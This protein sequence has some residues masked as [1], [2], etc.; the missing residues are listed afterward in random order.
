MTGSDTVYDNSELFSERY[1]ETGITRQSQWDCTDEAETA[2]S[3][4]VDLYDREYA[5][6]TGYTDNE[7]DTLDKW[8]EPVLETLGYEHLGETGFASGSGFVDRVL[9]ESHEDRVA[10]EDPRNDDDYATVYENAAT[11]LEAKPWDADFSTRFSE[12]RNY[13]NAS[14][15]INYYLS[16]LPRGTV[17]WGILTNGR[18]WRLYGT[19]DHQ[20]FIY[21][22]VDLPALIE[23]NETS[24]FKYFYCLF[25]SAAFRRST[26]SGECFLDRV[27]RASESTARQL[28]DDLQDNVFEAL[29]ILGDGFIATNDLEVTDT[30][31]ITPASLRIDGPAA[32]GF[33]LDDL[34]EQALI[35]LYRLMF[36]FYAES[37]DLLQPETTDNLRTY[38]AELSLIELRDEIVGLNDSPE[39]TAAT[40]LRRSTTH[41]QRLDTFFDIIDGGQE[42]IGIQAYDGGLF[43]QDEHEF[44]NQHPVSNHHLA[45]VI[46][47]LS[48][49]KI[50]E[51]YETVDYDDLKTRHLGAVYEGL[52]EHQFRLASTDMVAIH[53]DD[54][55]VWKKATEVKDDTATVDH[56]AAGNLYVATDEL[57]R[58]VSGSY[59][60]PK[61]IVDYI[62]HNTL[63]PRI[64][65]IHD[66]LESEGL[67]RGTAAYVRAFRESVLELDVLDPAMGS[68]HFLTQATTYLTR[69]I[70]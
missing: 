57:E 66:S 51:A 34:K 50:D 10:S 11:V 14:Q 64:E 36:V 1:L 39:E 9:F 43:D 16:H 46:F 19:G 49:T 48:T 63:D 41:W 37:R 12:D 8:I 29:A 38:D 62:I 15:Q 61:Y 59:Y 53:D 42:N 21:Y 6:V 18:H 65:A 24:A 52:L 23:R 13:F 45:Q 60:T 5:S 58:K 70:T 17:N 35:Y 28:G 54:E 20:T 56:V 27:Y 4:L 3:E 68:G 22:E 44:L 40:Y 55:E 30:G 25:R 33:T 47:L 7:E 32:E 2:L 67:E 26:S 69:S 31:T